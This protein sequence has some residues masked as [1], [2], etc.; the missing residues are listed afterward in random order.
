[1]D[2]CL[3]DGIKVACPMQD[4]DDFDQIVGELEENQVIGKI[5]NLGP[6]QAYELVVLGVEYDPRCRSR[7][8]LL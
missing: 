7:A 5:S 2:L 3:K 1:M 8:N 6:T 4:A